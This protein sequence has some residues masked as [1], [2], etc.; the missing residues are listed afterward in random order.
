[1]LQDFSEKIYDLNDNIYY[2]GIS[3]YPDTSIYKNYYKKFIITPDVSYR[4][5]KIAWKLW[6][7]EDLGWILKIINNFET[8]KDFKVKIEINYLE[9]N[10]LESLGL[11]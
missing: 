7:Q 11:V 6:G 1:M 4:P 8:I 9:Y 10:M 3:K 2:N 5:D